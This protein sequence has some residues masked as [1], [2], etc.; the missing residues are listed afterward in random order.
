MKD[1][2]IHY[3]LLN[4]FSYLTIYGDR[5]D[6]AKWVKKRTTDLGGK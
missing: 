2:S 6:L 4:S 5:G 1:L 3:P